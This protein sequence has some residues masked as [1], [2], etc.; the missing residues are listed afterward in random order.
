VLLPVMRDGR[1]TGEREPLDVL[2]DRRRD[3]VAALPERLRALE[4]E[5]PPYEVQIAPGLDALVHR[6][7]EQLGAP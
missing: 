1:R 5:S 3:A 7:H 4:P 6:L 2:R